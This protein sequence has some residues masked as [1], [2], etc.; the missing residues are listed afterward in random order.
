MMD[1]TEKYLVASAMARFGGGFVSRLGEAL[2]HADGNNTQRIH[3]AFSEYWKDYL[4]V[5]KDR[6]LDKEE[7]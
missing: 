3:D 7:Y 5:A 1:P 6:G 4:K 2:T